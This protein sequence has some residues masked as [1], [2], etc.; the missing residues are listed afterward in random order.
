MILKKGNRRKLLL[1][2]FIYFNFCS[3]VGDVHKKILSR[4]IILMITV[5]IRC[6]IICLSIIN[7]KFLF[8]KNFS[9]FAQCIANGA[10]QIC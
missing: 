4:H 1:E 7:D 8:V 10:E 5:L 2:E 9:H 3:G 6:M